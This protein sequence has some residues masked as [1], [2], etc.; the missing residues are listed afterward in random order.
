MK[1]ILLLTG[2]LTTLIL[3]AGC[4]KDSTN[5]KAGDE[6]DSRY[7]LAK[8]DIDSSL[9]ELDQDGND[10]SGWLGGIPLDKIAL[11][12]TVMF[13]SVN[14]WHIYAGAFQGPLQSWARIDSFRFSDSTGVYQQNRSILTD[15]FEHRLHRIYTFNNDTSGVNWEKTRNRNVMWDG[16]T[17]TV[18][19][20]T[21]NIQRSY[22]GQTPNWDFTHTM[23]GVFDSVKFNTE[24]FLNG[25]PTHPK[26]GQFTGSTVND[27]QSPNNSIH[28]A[29]DFTVT[30]Y[31]DHYHVHIVSGD[32]YW[33]WDHYYEI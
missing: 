10:G 12:D 14:F 29:T 2:M 11:D 24:D 23:S 26:S 32:N 33:D 22:T 4:S 1:R 21:G 31:A 13:D 9:A 17:D 5:T 28:I 20:L 27:R 6:N 18:L 19:V 16:F 8:A 25:L 7:I 15:K 30:F 3:A